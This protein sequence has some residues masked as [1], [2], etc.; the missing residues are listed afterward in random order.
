MDDEKKRPTEPV[1]EPEVRPISVKSKGDE[2]DHRPESTNEKR[3]ARDCAEDVDV[4]SQRPSLHPVQSHVSTHDAVHQ[5]QDQH[6]EQGDEIYDR[7]SRGHKM[8]IV[9][10]MSF[11][12][13]LAPI[14]ST[15]ILAASPEVVATFGK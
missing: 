1:E 11:C 9:C 5:D 7:F 13:L 3:K 6:Y 4:E 2:D 10:I 12:S 8:L 14:S 15:S